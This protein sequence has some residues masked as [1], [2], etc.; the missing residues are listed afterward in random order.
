M[1][2]E[3]TET[4]PPSRAGRRRADAAM[5][6]AQF[7]ATADGKQMVRQFEAYGMVVTE[8]FAQDAPGA[9]SSPGRTAPAR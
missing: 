5:E 1:H 3:I 2:D 6:A 9:G 4:P 8:T 7:R